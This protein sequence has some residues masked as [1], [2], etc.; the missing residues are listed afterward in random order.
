MSDKVLDLEQGPCAK[1]Y[2]LNI[3]Q[4]IAFH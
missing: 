2:L 3:L 4:Y 1:N